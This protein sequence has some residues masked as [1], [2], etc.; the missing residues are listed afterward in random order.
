MALWLQRPLMRAGELGGGAGLG[1]SR[2]VTAAGAGRVA[3][4]ARSTAWHGVAGLSCAGC[5]LVPPGCPGPV[6]E[7]RRRG[8]GNGGGSCDEG[9]LPAGHAADG[10]VVCRGG[11]AV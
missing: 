7:D 6:R 10:D 4:F 11:P 1:G 9:H 3:V 8:G 2:E 5:G